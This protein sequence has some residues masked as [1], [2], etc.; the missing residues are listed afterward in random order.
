MT[1]FKLTV[2]GTTPKSLFL[3]IGQVQ[4]S[5]LLEEKTKTKQ[6]RNPML[7]AASQKLPCHQSQALATVLKFPKR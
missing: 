6:K 1:G 7:Q 2:T 5:Q 4:T 3:R